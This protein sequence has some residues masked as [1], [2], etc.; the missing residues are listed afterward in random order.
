MSIYSGTILKFERTAVTQM[1][2]DV[3]MQHIAPLKQ[4]VGGTYLD[5]ESQKNKSPPK[6]TSSSNGLGEQ[7]ISQV[8]HFCKQRGE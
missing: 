2:S 1:T 3:S 8:V 5:V 6:L 4:C 7:K